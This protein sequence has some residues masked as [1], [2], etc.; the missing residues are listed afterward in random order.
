MRSGGSPYTV[1]PHLLGD[2][3]IGR[4]R[5]ARLEADGTPEAFMQSRAGSAQRWL[6]HA[7]RR[8]LDLRPAARGAQEQSVAIRSNQEQ[9]G[10][11]RS[12]LDR[13]EALRS[14]STWSWQPTSS[15]DGRYVE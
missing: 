5:L 12:S 13:P 10:A 11:I 8:V 4:H 6:P 15:T 14:Y 2:D 7:L 3:L 1:R 9:T